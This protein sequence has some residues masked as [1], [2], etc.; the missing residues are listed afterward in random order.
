MLKYV[1]F[2]HPISGSEARLISITASLSGTASYATTSSYDVNASGY[3][4]ASKFTT[5]AIDP[6]VA[7]FDTFGKPVLYSSAQNQSRLTYSD[8]QI[9]WILFSII[10]IVTNFTDIYN[11]Y[12]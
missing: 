2:L 5:P 12:M 10:P 11:S 8:G 1:Q 7:G 4:S 3:W 9:Q 6:A